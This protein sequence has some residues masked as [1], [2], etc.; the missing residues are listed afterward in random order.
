MARPTAQGNALMLSPDNGVTRERINDD[1]LAA[2]MG[3]LHRSS[4]GAAGLD[5]VHIGACALVHRFGS[6]LNTHVHC[7]C[8]HW[9]S[10]SPYFAALARI[11]QVC[12]SGAEANF[13]L[14]AA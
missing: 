13:P 10:V 3:S 9:A 2:L 14:P 11:A 6:S 4:P 8:S 1:Q 7:H 12:P 5:K